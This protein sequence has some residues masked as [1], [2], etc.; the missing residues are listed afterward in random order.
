MA[1]K[2]GHDAVA[3]GTSLKIWS[4]LPSS[5]RGARGIRLA[6]LALSIGIYQPKS[7][8]KWDGAVTVSELFAK[9]SS[10]VSRCAG[11][12]PV[13]P[14]M[15]TQDDFTD[16]TPAQQ[17]RWLEGLLDQARSCGTK[18]RLSKRSAIRAADK[19]EAKG[20]GIF[21]AY[22]CLWCHAW[23]IGHSVTVDA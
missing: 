22:C 15:I 2:S 18:L 13:H 17:V 21:D 14:A 8:S 16:L 19:M 9:E 5:R 10:G 6:K 3:S 11:S 23:H 12:S 7:A 4:W 1:Q 20:R